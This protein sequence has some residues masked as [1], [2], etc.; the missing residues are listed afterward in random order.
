[1]T[2]VMNQHQRMHDKVARR[3]AM[4]DVAEAPHP[5]LPRAETHATTR[6]IKIL[7]AA[8]TNR[9]AY[10]SLSTIVMTVDK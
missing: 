10:P 9:T 7:T 8:A 6:F 3:F 2:Q 5:K 4:G 1:M